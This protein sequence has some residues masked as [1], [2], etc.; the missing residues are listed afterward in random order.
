MAFEIQVI[1]GDGGRQRIVLGDGRT[2]VTAQPASQYRL[3][4][5]DGTVVTGA[6]VKR[7][8][9]D[10]VVQGLPDGR[11]LE[12][13][14]FFGACRPGAECTFALDALGAPAGSVLTSESDPLAALRD[15]SFLLYGTAEG[16][17]TAVVVPATAV[18]ASET[19]MGSLGTLGAG[20]LAIG[21]I[22][23]AGG[24]GGGGGGGDAVAAPVVTPPPTA[25]AGD[26]VVAPAPDPGTSTPPDPGTPPPPDPGTPPPPDPGTPPPPD[27]GTPPPPDPGTPPPPPDP[28]TP[29][30]PPPDPGT[31]PPPPPPP[32]D[33]GTPPPP[34]PPPPGVASFTLYDDRGRVVG[35]IAPGGTT[36]DVTPRVTLRLDDVLGAGQTL[37]LRIDDVVSEVLTRGSTLDFEEN[38]LSRG[39]HTY[40]AEIS[41]GFGN[42]STL[43][44]NGALLG[45]D[46][47]F[48][49]A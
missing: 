14:N 40:T 47:T 34:A 3:V 42:V 37:T 1:A 15:G 46:F 9:N 43:D 18:A 23:A 21:A 4:A 49:I 19:G 29:P 41:D 48:R 28:G 11:E 6:S 35:P 16:G 5:A 13:D 24:G 32:P 31:P 27:P 45:T 36:D 10:L 8:G 7:F 22:A 17:T 44:L 12:L 33:P 25:V 38:R 26:L 2:V 20:L 39:S 30:P